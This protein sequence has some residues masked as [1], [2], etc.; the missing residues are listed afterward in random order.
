M[1]ALLK[2]TIKRTKAPQAGWH[3]PNEHP[4]RG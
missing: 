1:G 4:G 2:D 3:A